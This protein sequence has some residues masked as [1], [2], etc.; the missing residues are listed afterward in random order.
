[1]IRKDIYALAQGLGKRL[2]DRGDWVMFSC[3]NAPYSTDHRGMDHH[4]SFGVH[5]NDVGASTCHCFTCGIKGNLSHVFSNLAKL[6][7]QLAQAYKFVRS[8]DS[9]NASTIWQRKKQQGQLLQ[10]AEAAQSFDWAKFVYACKNNLQEK[11]HAYR[12]LIDRGILPYE[13]DKYNIGYDLARK[14]IVYPI[15]DSKKK[16]VGA[17]GR[18]SMYTYYPEGDNR[19]LLGE[20]HLDLSEKEIF[21]VEGPVDF[22]VLKRCFRNVLALGGKTLS[23]ERLDRLLNFGSIITVVLD[24]DA[25]NSTIKLAY[26]LLQYK[27]V[28]V[29]MLPQDKDPGAFIHEPVALQEF[30]VKHKKMF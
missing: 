27:R 12:T 22:I 21:L 23:K 28:F 3:P 16:F 25:R 8:V 11:S 1:M 14:K 30:V 24:G 7:K 15:G 6:D 5:V 4:P 29:V 2:V 10:M 17:I 9:P 19:T 13:L 26:K 20:N 18:D